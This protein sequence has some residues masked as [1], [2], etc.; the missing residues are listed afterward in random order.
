VALW[1]SF[2]SMLSPGGV[3][4][5]PDGSE[6]PGN[7]LILW[8]T[9]STGATPDELWQWVPAGL[10]GYFV[11][12]ST[13][14][15]LVIDV[16]GASTAPD[17]PIQTWTPNLTDAQLWQFIPD[18]AGS[19]YSSIQ[20]KLS[21]PGNPLVINV[22]GGSAA[23]GTPLILY[24]APAAGPTPDELWVGMVSLPPPPPVQPTEQ[25]TIAALHYPN[26]NNDFQYGTP[27]TGLVFAP[28]NNS[29]SIIAQSESENPGDAGV[30]TVTTTPGTVLTLGLSWDQLC[31]FVTSSGG[32]SPAGQLITSSPAIIYLQMNNA[33]K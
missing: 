15:G 6:E 5:V 14:N 19:G 3:I 4:N 22:Q 23:E 12:Q 11:I 28:A 32:P 33:T 18:P 13:I 9:P 27:F 8:P 21:S 24:S 25:W 30:Y 7:Q 10:S 1:V 2:M 20:S 17:T 16:R 31:S 26:D 29:G